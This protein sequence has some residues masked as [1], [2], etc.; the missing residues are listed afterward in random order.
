MD[1]EHSP[2]VLPRTICKCAWGVFI[3]AKKGNL[4]DAGLMLS[5]GE[6][7]SIVS[8]FVCRGESCIYREGSCNLQ[9]NITFPFPNKQQMLIGNPRPFFILILILIIL[10]IMFLLI[11]RRL[12]HR[13]LT[14]NV[15]PAPESSPTNIL[16][17]L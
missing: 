2:P 13:P 15:P 7:L 16:N 6:G 3:E 5:W 4:F 17:K 12:F 8:C 9:L 10:T 14:G 1:A 11:L